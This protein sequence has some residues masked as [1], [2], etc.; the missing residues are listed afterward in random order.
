MGF[1]DISKLPFGTQ[2]LKKKNP[3]VADQIPSYNEPAPSTKYAFDFFGTSDPSSALI[4]NDRW[5]MVGTYSLLFFSFV[6]N[7]F[8]VLKLWYYR[9]RRRSIA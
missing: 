3:S 7:V 1:E 8:L 6:L 9:R 5:N 4:V 2:N